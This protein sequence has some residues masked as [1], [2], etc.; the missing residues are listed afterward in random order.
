[1][2]GSPSNGHIFTTCPIPHPPCSYFMPYMLLLSYVSVFRSTSLS[3]AF[4]FN[5]R[6]STWPLYSRTSSSA[7]FPPS[8]AHKYLVLFHSN[9]RFTTHVLPTTPVLL[10]PQFTQLQHPPHNTILSYSHAY[11]SMH[12]FP[13]PCLPHNPSSLQNQPTNQPTNQL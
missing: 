2:G 4:I 12:T 13:L 1:M 9:L 10:I 6:V 3:L 7:W 5:P 11:T 8:T